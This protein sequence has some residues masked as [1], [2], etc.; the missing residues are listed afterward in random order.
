MRGDYGPHLKLRKDV[1]KWINEQ[2]R[3]GNHSW[4]AG[5]EK[6]RKM[7]IERQAELIAKNVPQRKWKS[8]EKVR[9][10]AK[11]STYIEYDQSINHYS[12]SSLHR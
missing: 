8:N 5:I 4:V 10:L 11:E 3:L 6:D 1:A 9:D 7:R 2:L 12:L